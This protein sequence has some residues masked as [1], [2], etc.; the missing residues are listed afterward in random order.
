MATPTPA[1]Y[2]DRFYG[3]RHDGSAR[4]AESVL[5]VLGHLRLGPFDRVVDVGCGRGEWLRTLVQGGATVAIGV[6]GDW[7]A[8][9][10]AE[11]DTIE[12]HSCNLA[13][14][15]SADL[16]ARVGTDRF[17]LAMSVEALEH[18]PAPAGAQVVAAL[19]AWSDLVLFSAA[20]PGQ[21]GRGHENE[22]WQ[23]AWAR[24]FATHGYEPYDLIRPALWDRD[25]V[26]PWYRQNIIVYSPTPPFE[27]ATPTP[28]E[29]L[30]IVHPAI[31]EQRRQELS[32]PELARAASGLAGRRFTNLRRRFSRS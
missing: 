27:G 7:N 26:E 28:A 8:P 5:G 21:G 30:D 12:F 4:S 9:A 3:G 11:D 23:S 18:L 15:T 1:S 31:F 32:G 2:T 6:D 29:R 24:E 16:L 17:D 25:S 20:V 22:Q 14:A 10:F 13:T 19:V